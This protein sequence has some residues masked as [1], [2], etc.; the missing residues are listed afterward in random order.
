MIGEIGG[1]AEEEMRVE[2]LRRCVGRLFR[3]DGATSSLK[4]R[5]ACK[6]EIVGLVRKKNTCQ[7]HYLFLKTSR[8]KPGSNAFIKAPSSCRKI[9]EVERKNAV[10]LAGCDSATLNS[11]EQTVRQLKEH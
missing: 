4:G 10:K 6:K 11:Y 7:H 3:A 1:H 9:E 8:L 5:R 2:Q